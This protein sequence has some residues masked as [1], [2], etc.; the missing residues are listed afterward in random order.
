MSVH[1]LIGCILGVSMTVRKPTALRKRELGR[2]NQPMRMVILC[3]ARDGWQ[4]WIQSVVLREFG[5]PLVFRPHFPRPTYPLIKGI[6]ISAL[7]DLGTAFH[8]QGRTLTLDIVRLR[9]AREL[10]G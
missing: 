5:T 3:S 7:R 9:L 4:E 6:S 2:V 8:G 1:V 10:L